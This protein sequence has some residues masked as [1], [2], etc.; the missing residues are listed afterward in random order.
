MGVKTTDR[1]KTDRRVQRTR[2]KVLDAVR[3]TLVEEGAAAVTHQRIAAAAG[4]ARATMYLHWPEPMHLLLDSIAEMPLPE[5]VPITGDLRADLIAALGVMQDLLET[6]S[7]VA[8]FADLLARA[9]GDARWAEARHA[10]YLRADR[11]LRQLLAAARDD[12]YLST[13]TV[14]T[15][16]AQLLGPLLFRRLVHGAAVGDHFVAEVVD[17]FLA[18]TS[19]PS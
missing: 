13:R 17:T 7:V 9:E 8:V 2:R 15:A 19:R 18:S 16:L 10:L 4:V 14:D 5:E 12:G 6:P 11:P 1:V 3:A